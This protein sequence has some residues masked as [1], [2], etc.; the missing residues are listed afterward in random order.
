VQCT[1]IVDAIVCLGF[2]EQV[3]NMRMARNA[4]VV[5][6]RQAASVASISVCTRTDEEGAHSD[7]AMFGCDNE[8]RSACFVCGV[9]AQACSDA[10]PYSLLQTRASLYVAHVSYAMN[11][12]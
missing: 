3:Q 10:S 11:D 12:P 5:Q 4:A 1:A 9:W 7:V 6:R 8:G 2:Q